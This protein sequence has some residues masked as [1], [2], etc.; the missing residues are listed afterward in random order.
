M[1]KILPT[2]ERIRATDWIDEEKYPSYYANR[3][4][5]KR[6]NKGHLKGDIITAGQLVVSCAIVKG[7]PDIRVKIDGHSRAEAWIRGQLEMP[8]EITLMI[9]EVED[10]AELAMLYRS[11][12]NRNASETPS[13]YMYHINKLA[14]FK[15]TSGLMGTSWKHVYNILGYKDREGEAIFH[16]NDALHAMDA[17][18]CPKPKRSDSKYSAAIRAAMLKTLQE[19]PAKAE[20]FWAKYRDDDDSSCAEVNRVRES[21]R[22]NGAAGAIAVGMV[23]A[24]A[25]GAFETYRD[26]H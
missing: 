18:G 8:D 9:Y 25:L 2:V 17:W 1:R 3:N 6:M 12:N 21:I 22:D 15:P 11:F 7:Q 24:T 19:H 10:L 26:K 16:F 4:V 13:E 20:A 5:K 14:D 23:F